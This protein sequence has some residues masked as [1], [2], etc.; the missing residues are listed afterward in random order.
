MTSLSPGTMV[1]GYRIESV[2]GRGGM[3]TVYR[4]TQESLA[5]S[6]ALKVLHPSRIRDGGAAEAFLREAVNAAAI[7]H[8]ALV[9]VHDLVV[10]HEHQVYAYA[11]ELVPGETAARVVQLHGPLRRAQA[12]YLLYQASAG[13]AAA[14][15]R[16]LVHRD[17][18]PENLMVQPDG[19]VR[20]LDLGLAWDRVGSIGRSGSGPKI[21]RVI[22]TPEFAAP[23]QLRDPDRISAAADVWGLGATLVWLMCGKPPFTGSTLVDLVVNAVTTEPRLSSQLDASVCE[24]IDL[25]LAKDPTERPTDAGQVQRILQ[26][27]ARG[28]LPGQVKPGSPD[29][30]H[31]QPEDFA[32]SHQ[33]T[34]GVR[35]PMPTRRMR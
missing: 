35:R 9:P 32:H 4:A 5:R 26:G 15:T 11:M 30:G 14:H 18:K 2:L 28:K 7:R 25:L 19:R 24:L 3:G 27:M 1:G 12:L 21:V 29:E 17:V 31:P 6:V 16:G 34:S 20:L 13:L 22:G 23:E 10:D 33:P 8:P